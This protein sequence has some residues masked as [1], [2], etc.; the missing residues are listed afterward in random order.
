MEPFGSTVPFA[1]PAWYTGVTTPYYTSK[2]I[3]LRSFL[4]SYY[5]ENIS[6]HAGEW[7]AQGIVPK[8]VVEKHGKEGFLAAAVFPAAEDKYYEGVKKLAGIERGEWDIWCDLIMA[9]ESTRPGYLG[10]N[11]GLGGG[12]GIGAPPIASWGTPEQ[13]SKFLA[14]VLR[15]EMR[16]CLGITEASGGSDVAGLL[17]TARRS[18]D[19]NSFIV[20]GSKK[21]ITNAIDADFM[22][23]AV[24]TGGAGAS[25][26]S[27]LII[28]LN[29]KG[30]TRRKID[31]TGVNASGSTYVEFEDVLVPTSNLLGKE[32]FGFQ[33]IMTNFLHERLILCIQANRM[34][35]ICIEDAYD[36]A[37]TRKTFGK[38]L[39]EQPVI[40]AKFSDMGRIVTAN[41]SWIEQ[42][43]HHIASVPKAQADMDLAGTAALC[44]VSCTRGL[45]ICCREALQVL[46]GVGYQ[47][48][49]RGGRVEQ[50]SRDL[51]VM[52]VGGGSDEILTDLGLRMEEKKMS[53]LKTKS[54]KL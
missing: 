8:H 25:G 36:Y 54:A 34:A 13:K 3:K 18:P 48:G 9:D 28:P 10:V 20:N 44:K 21:W 15:G 37:T 53:V 17:T 27:L 2:H 1:E 35:R 30:V 49:G 50:I 32:N 11:W 31:N 7:E 22:T 29:L 42:I 39:I 14:P 12:N 23:T 24:R 38:A 16:C 33:I 45:E 51:R 19:G 5:D 4:R 43:A 26:V 41:H 46:G 47:R 40:R 6:P 52:C